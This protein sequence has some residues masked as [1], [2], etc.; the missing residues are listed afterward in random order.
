M[1]TELLT[2]RRAL[3]PFEPR[4]AAIAERVGVFLLE[5]ACTLG[6]FLGGSAAYGAADEL[7]DCDLF[8]CVCDGASGPLGAGLAREF[9]GASGLL[10]LAQG[11]SFPWMG[12]LSSLFFADPVGFVVDIGVFQ[13]AELPQFYVEPEA[14]VIRD[15]AGAIERRRAEV[16]A[17]L[18]ARDARRLR[19]YLEDVIG[20]LLKI[21]KAMR[22]NHVWGAREY[23]E[24]CRRSLIYALR[25][26]HAIGREH[27]WLGRPERDIE[28]HADPKLIAPLDRTTTIYSRASI[29]LATRDIMEMMLSLR[30]VA[31]YPAP[32]A[33]M[34]WAW[35]LLEDDLRGD[36]V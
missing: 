2:L 29:A 7:S 16:R 3:T 10:H 13:H 27:P 11:R 8:V 28:S 19:L 1:D 14:Q 31:R 34:V 18:P 36:L 32:R 17:D 9:L 15:H 4:R 30:C 25:V 5:Q 22:R 24:K 6:L 23:V 12:D 26:E 20:H 33:A 21:R 35:R